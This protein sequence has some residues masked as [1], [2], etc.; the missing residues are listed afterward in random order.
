MTQ[1]SKNNSY[2]AADFERY[3]AGTMTAA[4]RHALEKA[5]LDDPFLADALEGYRLTPTPTADMEKIR[6]RLQPAEERRSFFLFRN[7]LFRAAAALVLVAGIAWLAYTLTQEKENTIANETI[8]QTVPLR[9]SEPVPMPNTVATDSQ[10]VVSAPTG[11]GNKQNLNYKQPAEGN[12]S[13]P[14]GFAYHIADTSQT[15]AAEEFEVDKI[16]NARPTTNQANA[17]LSANNEAGYNNVTANNRN[18]SLTDNN[19]LVRQQSRMKAENVISNDNLRK[20]VVNNSIKDDTAS[21]RTASMQGRVA[22]VTAM[23][24]QNASVPPPDT[25]KN[26]DV[27]LQEQK[28]EME[29]VV[30]SGYTKK[31]AVAPRRPQVVADTLEPEEGFVQ[32]DHYIA[33]NLKRPEELKVKTISGEVQLS[34][35]VN[36]NG[37]P[38]NITVVKSLC[39]KCDE[40]AVRLLKEG[41]KWKKKKNK[42]GSVTIRF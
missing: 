26:F 14:K 20:Q 30:V 35:E 33:D 31:S 5:A 37:E 36:N 41:P 10:L 19:N 11:K 15:K 4:E 18:P 38:V 32:F 1:S 39:N 23:A 17:R 13:S 2:T 24:A 40:E 25:L 7:P 29:E 8:Q 12:L 42:K 34:F 27:V 3:Y 6:A 16:A 28:R 21:E 9:K 22:G